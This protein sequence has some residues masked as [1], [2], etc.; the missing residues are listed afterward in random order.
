MVTINLLCTYCG[1]EKWSRNGHAPH[2]KQRYCCHECKR[3]SREN[4]SSRKYSEE[5]KGEI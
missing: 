2:G 5:R 3:Y 4:P 1:S